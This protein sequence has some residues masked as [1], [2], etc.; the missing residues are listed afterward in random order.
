MSIYEKELYDVIRNMHGCV[1]YKLII[2]GKSHYDEFVKELKNLPNESRS[3]K[4]VLT[5]MERYSPNI[6][7]PKERF[8]KIEG[9]KRSDVFEFKD[10]PCVRIYVVIQKENIYIV[11]GSLKKEQDATISRVARLLKGFKIEE[12]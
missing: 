1:Y 10:R 4:K 7:L 9:I 8:R 3:L 6:L 12:I 5:L 11:D 2:D